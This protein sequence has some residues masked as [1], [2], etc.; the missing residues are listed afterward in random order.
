MAFDSVLESGVQKGSRLFIATSKQLGQL[1]YT[2][3]LYVD[4]CNLRS[5]NEHD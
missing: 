5:P 2:G 1:F 3:W 4:S